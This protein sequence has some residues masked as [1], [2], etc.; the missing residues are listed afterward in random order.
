M[1]RRTKNDDTCVAVAFILIIAVVLIMG[2]VHWATTTPAVRP[3]AFLLL[4]GGALLYVRRSSARRTRNAQQAQILDI[5]SREIA[6]YHVMGPSEFEDA[7]AYLCRRDGCRDARRV[8]GAGDLGADVTAIAPDGRRIVI[9]CKRYG[10]TTNVGSPDLQK[11]GGTCF[12][13][14]G[15]QV[16]AVVTTSRFT[17]PATGYAQSIGIRL[18]DQ[19]ALAA[20]ASRTGPAPWML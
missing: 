2:I 4:F 14:H 19:H 7:I 15:A 1:P 6:R 3:V 13:V 5:Q 11:F 10:P 9:Q 8:G 17:K 18:F 16:A 12:A 20:W